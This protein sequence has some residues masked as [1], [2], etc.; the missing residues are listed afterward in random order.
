MIWCKFQGPGPTFNTFLLIYIGTGNSKQQRNS[1]LCKGKK[2]T[3]LAQLCLTHCDPMDC[4]PPGF[5]V[6]GIL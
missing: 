2:E 3:V 4:S 5:S 6:H 1:C